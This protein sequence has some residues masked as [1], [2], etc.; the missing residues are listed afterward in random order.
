MK[1]NEER[2]RMS[3]NKILLER[4]PSPLKLEVL[5]VQNWRVWRKQ[6]AKFP[7][8]YSHQETCYIVRGK[9]TVT[10][11]GE[12]AQSF[13]RGDLIYLFTDGFSDQ[14]HEK[15]NTQSFGKN[16]LKELLIEINRESMRRQKEILIQ[17]FEEWKGNLPQRDDVL[18]FGIRL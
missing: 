2:N 12:P 14:N 4:K 7:W 17:R 1:L 9:F 3:Q 16:R 13:Q 11:D 18:I 15:E 6:V 5:G 10:P 8:V